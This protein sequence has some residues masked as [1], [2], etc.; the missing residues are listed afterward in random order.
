[1]LFFNDAFYNVMDYAPF[2]MLLEKNFN[3]IDTFVQCN[4]DNYFPEKN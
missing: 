3:V 1:M 2:L 4:G